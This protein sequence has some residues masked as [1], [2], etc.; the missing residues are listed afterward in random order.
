MVRHCISGQGL[1]SEHI[2]DT[3]GKFQALSSALRSLLNL[4]CFRWDSFLALR[5]ALIVSWFLS[6]S[7]TATAL[8]WAIF[9]NFVLEVG[10][11]NVEARGVVLD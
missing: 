6:G 4:V 8:T 10:V 1:N 7:L 11:T 2:R 9:K 3:E 5:L